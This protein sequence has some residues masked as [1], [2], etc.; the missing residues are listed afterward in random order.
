MRGKRAVVLGG[1]GFVG[2][3]LCE[4]LLDD[5]AEA[6]LAVD[7]LITGNEE[8]V[9]TLKPRAG[10]RYV[11][12]DIIDGLEVEGPVDFVFNMASPASPIDYANLPLETLRVGSI[13]TENA[14][15]L[16]EKKKA[17]FLMASTSEVYG[18]PLVH[19]QKEDYWGN[20]NPI[21]PRSVY[22]EA[23]RYSEAISAAY[24]RSR[25]V[26]V[27]IVRIFN[28][29]GPRMRLNDG[30]VV[31]AFVGQALKGEDFSVFG[32]GSQTRSFCY[33]KDL[34]D[35]LVRL[36]LSDV[37]GPVNI[38]NPR[39]MTIKQFAE[40]VREAAG[41]GRQ[42]VYQ[43]LPKDDPKQRQPDITRARTLLGWEPK[44]SLEEGLR[45]TIAYFREV[46]GRPP[47]A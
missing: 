42:I 8:N 15:K 33:V 39:E 28:T 4:R 7:N 24:E 35:G 37:R 44:V 6:V 40:A 5:G 11:K 14:L 31:P 41:G 46:A 19:P 22:D 29:Y 12:Q 9:R 34:V 10:F 38:G 2:S 26:N 43:P 13:G 30:R 47:G 20:V 23:K 1:A 17:V 45:E 16:A 27:R 21:G 25:G 36:V 18:D 32:D 3:H